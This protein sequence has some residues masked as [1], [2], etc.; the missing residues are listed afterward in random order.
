MATETIEVLELAQERS[1][2]RQGKDSAQNSEELKHFREKEGPRG[3]Q[4]E[5]RG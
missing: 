4:K 3:S 2:E 5:V 1:V